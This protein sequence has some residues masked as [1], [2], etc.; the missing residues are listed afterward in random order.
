MA[1]LGIAWSFLKKN[2]WLL[3]AGAAGI[4]VAW[5]KVLDAQKE[6]AQ[7]AAE[8]N[9]RA[10]KLAAEQLRRSRRADRASK[11]VRQQGQEIEEQIEK[12]SESGQ[13]PSG[14]W[15]DDRLRDQD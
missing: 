13:R 15:T 6:R 1:W 10:A 4:L 12:R 5:M 11:Q 8:R 9:E 14:R 3:I 7:A 2:T